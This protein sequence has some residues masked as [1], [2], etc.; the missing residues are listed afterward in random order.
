MPHETVIHGHA[1]GPFAPMADVLAR[2]LRRSGEIGAAV[3]VC[4]RGRLVVDLWGGARDAATGAPMEEDTMV[5]VFSTGKGVLA[6]LV[7]RCVS[8]GRFSYDD[9]IAAHWPAFA[10][11]GKQAITVADVLDHR[12]GLALFGRRVRRRDL[13]D[14][15]AM[16]RILEAMT[17]VWP[18]GTAWGYHLGTF[19]PILAELLRRTDPDGRSV[20]DIFRRDVAL[21]LG[22]DFHFGMPETAPERRRARI[23]LPAPTTAPFDL[24][25]APGALARQALN[26]FSLLYR[27]LWEIRDMRVNSRDWLR[28]EFPSANGVGTVRA[29]ALLYGMLADGGGA[30][31]ISP[32]VAGML[33]APPQVPPEGARDRVMGIDH[34][35]RLGFTRPSPDFAFSPSPR[36]LGM[37][38]LGG[39]FAFAEPDR[40]FGYAYAPIR[41]GLLPFDDPREKALRGELHRIVSGIDGG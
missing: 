19:G 8:L 32:A 1:D 41:L 6:M 33:T 38:G 25:R 39:S 18:P 28:Q 14:R 23:S 5:P 37:P 16:A 21:P 4:H 27:T 29:L 34:R 26:P 10:A 13:A 2:T 17:P 3:A 12:S 40:G 7:A 20:A 22:I 9:P 31:G 24:L 15:E 11:D 35:Y 30:L 36:A